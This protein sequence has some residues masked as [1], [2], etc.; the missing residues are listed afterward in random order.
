MR[1]FKQT[2]NALSVAS[3]G[4]LCDIYKIHWVVE[5]WVTKNQS[6]HDEDFWMIEE[7]F[8]AFDKALAYFNN[9]KKQGHLV[10]VVEHSIKT[11]AHNSYIARNC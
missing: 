11:V 4:L 2:N 6:L 5:K 1:D 9:L 10:R 3:N 8:N 7:E